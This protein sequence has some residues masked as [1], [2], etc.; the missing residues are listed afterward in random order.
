[1]SRERNPCG[2]ACN[3]STTSSL[4]GRRLAGCPQRHRRPRP[5]RG[6]PGNDQGRAGGLPLVA[7]KNIRRPRPRYAD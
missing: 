3:D 5:A 4:C 1:V 6:T 7:R 2:S